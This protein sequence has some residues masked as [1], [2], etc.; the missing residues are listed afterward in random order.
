M[1][2][3]KALSTSRGYETTD[4]VCELMKQI[5]PE[6]YLQEAIRRIREE[7]IEG[8]VGSGGWGHTHRCPSRYL[9][10]RTMTERELGEILGLNKFGP[11]RNL[12]TRIEACYSTSTTVTSEIERPNEMPVKP[13]RTSSV[14]TVSFRVV[15][16]DVHGI[17]HAVGVP[18]RGPHET[19]NGDADIS[20]PQ[21]Q[22]P[23]SGG[24]TGVCSSPRGQTGASSVNP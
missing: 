3:R 17:Q 19:K 2:K 6:V 12:F 16:V 15:S 20:K 21:T 13:T 1:S 8:E 9:A 5:C 7:A 22:P 14:A 11:R 23:S 10:L 4:E 24:A 18:S